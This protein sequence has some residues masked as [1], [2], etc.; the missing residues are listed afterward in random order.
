MKIKKLE[1]KNFA[2]YGNRTQIIEF[3]NEKCDLFLVLGQN[4]AGKCLAK[5]TEIFVEI[6]DEELK[7]EFIEFIINKK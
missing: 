1:F 5:E 3:D 7:K 6:K 2:S 4:G